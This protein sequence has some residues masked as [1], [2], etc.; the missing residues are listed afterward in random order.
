MGLP[1][2]L[3]LGENF[4]SSYGNK[5]FSLKLDIT[6]NRPDAFSHIG[7]ARDISCKTNR[8]FKKIIP[9]EVLSG[10]KISFDIEMEN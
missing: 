1:S 4:T 8:N 5:Y 6:P 7:V 9:N 10:K 2:N 3:P